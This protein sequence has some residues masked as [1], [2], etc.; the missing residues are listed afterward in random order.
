MSGKIVRNKMI[1]RRE[2]V[3]GDGISEADSEDR[4]FPLAWEIILVFINRILL[5][6]SRRNPL[7]TNW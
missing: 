1:T 7:L 2:G 6:E 3:I 4:W 5:A